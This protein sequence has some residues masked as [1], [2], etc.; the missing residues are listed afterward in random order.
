MGTKQI[1]LSV[2]EAP[3]EIDYFVQSFIDHIMGGMLSVLKG[4]GEIESLDVTIEGDKV[5]TNLN[6]SVVQ[7]NPFVNTIIRNTIAGMVSSLKGVGDTN[8]IDISIRR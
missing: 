2:N 3:I 5:T 6:N 4:T 1:T 7:T 8:R